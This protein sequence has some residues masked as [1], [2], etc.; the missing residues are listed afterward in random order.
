[1]TWSENQTRQWSRTRTIGLTTYGTRSGGPHRIEIWWFR[2][3]GRFVVTGTPGPRDWYANVLNTPEVVV[4]VGREE[5][6]ALARPIGDV[7]FR[8]RFFAH[9]DASWY[10]SA[11][12]FERLVRDAP[13]VEVIQRPIDEP[14]LAISRPSI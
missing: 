10:S 8:R 13:M 12:A 3:E 7:P 2:F 1:M 5:V 9:A 11:A 6:A 14:S 4:H